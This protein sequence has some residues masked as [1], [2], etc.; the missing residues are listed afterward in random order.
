MRNLLRNASAMPHC[1]PSLLPAITTE[2]SFKKG[3]FLPMQEYANDE[4]IRT[5]NESMHQQLTHEFLFM[6]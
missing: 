5:V 4:R 3:V 6:R 2:N 1:R